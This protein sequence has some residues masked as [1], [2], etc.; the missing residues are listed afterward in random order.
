[1]GKLLIVKKT[2]LF[3]SI[4]LSTTMGVSQC[5]GVITITSQEEIDDFLTNYPNCDGTGLFLDINGQNS[6]INNLQGLSHLTTIGTLGIFFT[7]LTDLSGLDNIAE[8]S[9]LR[10]LGNFNLLS[11]DG[12]ESLQS[13]GFGGFRIVLNSALVSLE[14]L[15]GLIEVDGDFN[16]EVNNALES[17]N[18]LNNLTRVGGS[19]EIKSQQSLINL[20]GL[21]SLEQVGSTSADTFYL[22][23]SE[24]V[25]TLEGLENLR[26]VNG[27]LRIRLFN[28]LN[29]LSG[30]SGL[31]TVTTRVNLQDNA[32]LSFCGI[33]LICNNLDNTNIELIFANNALGCSSIQEVVASCLLSLN[34]LDLSNAFTL[35]PNPVS[36]ILQIHT[37]EGVVLQ[38]TTVYSLLGKELIATSEETIDFSALSEGLYFVGVLTNLGRSLKMILKE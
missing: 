16:I 11:F 30:F 1:M 15:S 22:F 10:I 21:E 4:V 18:G 32:Q 17:L 34:E 3:L 36:E 12:L 31:E 20:L 25:E 2:L 23:N 14:G 8:T 24:L 13:V 26:T 19:F 29:S 6:N 27:T 28:S 5:P 35:Y 33:D 38:K 7:E 37:S 9:R